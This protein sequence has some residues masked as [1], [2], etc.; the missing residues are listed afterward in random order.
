M[1]DEVKPCV[2]CGG[3]N[4]S[5]PQPGHPFGDCKDCMAERKRKQR[6]DPVRGEIMRKLGRERY[7]LYRERKLKLE[8]ERYANDSLYRE[9][10][11][12]SDRK[13]YA[14]DPLYR[15]KKGQQSTI[16]QMRRSLELA[17]KRAE[18]LY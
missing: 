11:L 16:R 3:T 6:Q 13:R 18:E 14:E 2:R 7:P 15:L 5:K 10:K 8:R 12:E 1:S 17:I 9:A 4:R